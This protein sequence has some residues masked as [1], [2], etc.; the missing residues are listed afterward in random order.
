MKTNITLDKIFNNIA[1]L[2][3]AI[4]AYKLEFNYLLE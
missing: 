1:F 4:R 3:I 2:D